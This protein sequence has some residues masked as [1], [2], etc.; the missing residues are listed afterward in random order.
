MHRKSKILRRKPRTVV[1]TKGKATYNVNIQSRYFFVAYETY[2]SMLQLCNRKKDLESLICELKLV[3]G[4]Q[5]S[6][7]ILVT[8]F[9]ARFDKWMELIPKERTYL[10]ARVFR[11]LG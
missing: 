9:Q 3:L 1:A 6:N 10:F 5:N 8:T 11:K 4:F 7:E 2:W